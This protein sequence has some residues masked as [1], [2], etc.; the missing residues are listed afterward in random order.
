MRFIHVAGP[1]SVM[2]T[3]YSIMV[4]M[5]APVTEHCS[6]A[7]RTTKIYVMEK[8][9]GYHHNK[10]CQ[11]NFSLRF[12]LK[13]QWNTVIRSEN[14][15]FVYMSMGSYVLLSRTEI[16]HVMVYTFLHSLHLTT[17]LHVKIRWQMFYNLLLVNKIQE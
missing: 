14:I 1:V 13:K 11:L 15:D 7:P 4:K 5:A 3:I 9:N 2:T 12:N 16:F 6:K 8:T 10:G 17:F